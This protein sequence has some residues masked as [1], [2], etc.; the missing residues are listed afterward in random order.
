[1]RLG[2]RGYYKRVP[3]QANHDDS[4]DSTATVL[5][6]RIT[7]RSP[8]HSRILH[9]S[10]PTHTR[11]QDR[12]LGPSGLATGVMASAWICHTWFRGRK[13]RVA[14][15]LQFAARPQPAGI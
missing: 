12:S 10:L 11:N 13:P 9:Y 3:A 2:V 4:C 5:G 7:L 14:I 1:M 6:Y 8:S 15:S